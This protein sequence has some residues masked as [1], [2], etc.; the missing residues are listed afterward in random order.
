MN[1]SFYG[2]CKAFPISETE[3]KLLSQ[4]FG[5]LAVFGA[6]KFIEKNSKNC[7]NDRD[8]I[9]QNIF[10]DLIKASSYSKRQIYINKC[11]LACN[12]YIKDKFMRKILKTLEMLWGNRTK[13]GA[14][15]QVFGKCQ[16]DI[17]E[18][19]VQTYVPDKKKPD[20]KAPLII[21]ES[22]AKYAKSAL[23]NNLRGS[24]R[25]ITRDKSINKGMV[26]LSDFNYMA[27]EI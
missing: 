22:F 5:G 1:E 2:I 23:W 9:I 7:Y 17:L 8:D 3:Y 24:G 21:D 4:E 10:C 14:N 12:R 20:K 18:K 26:S 19:L 15:R 13:H 6:K 27:K 11:F 25:K 16:E